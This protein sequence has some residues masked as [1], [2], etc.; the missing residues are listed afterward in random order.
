MAEACPGYAAWRVRQAGCQQ[1]LLHLHPPPSLFTP[2]LTA[3]ALP[4][5]TSPT[6]EAG[7][8]ASLA[9]V[10]GPV[11]SAA[12]PSL[13]PLGATL[14]LLLSFIIWRLLRCCC[15]CCAHV[16]RM[17]PKG[18]PYKVRQRTPGPCTPYS[19]CHARRSGGQGPLALLPEAA[20]GAAGGRSPCWCGEEWGLQGVDAAGCRHRAAKICLFTFPGLAHRCHPG[21]G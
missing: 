1:A 14:A 8:T 11:L 5:A 7:V 21:H 13:I 20:G 12:W 3:Q 15:C 9:Y 18:V 17:P 6:P 16:R 4:L 2:R 19:C 10:K